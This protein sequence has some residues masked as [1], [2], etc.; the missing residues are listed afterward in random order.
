MG[1]D[2]LNTNSTKSIPLTITHWIITTP[3]SITPTSPGAASNESVASDTGVGGHSVHWSQTSSPHIVADHYI[4]WCSQVRA[5]GGSCVWCVQT[6]HMLIIVFVI[7]TKHTVTEALA[8]PDT[9][10]EFVDRSGMQQST[11]L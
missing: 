11:N 6:H 10:N 1:D 4:G 3:H 8:H 2:T 7:H 9:R 5:G